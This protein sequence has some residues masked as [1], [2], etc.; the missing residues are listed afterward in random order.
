MSDINIIS[1][2]MFDHKTSGHVSLSVIN[3]LQLWHLFPRDGFLKCSNGHDLK[4]CVDAHAM[5]GYTWR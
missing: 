1:L 5:D 4:L 3:R 2:Y